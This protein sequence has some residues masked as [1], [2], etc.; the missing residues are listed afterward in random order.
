MVVPDST[1]IHLRTVINVARC[2]SIYDYTTAYWLTVTRCLTVF[3]QYGV[4]VPLTLDTLNIPVKLC[5]AGLLVGSWST[6]QDATLVYHH[7]PPVVIDTVL[8]G[9]S[10]ADSTVLLTHLPLTTNV[11]SPSPSTFGTDWRYDLLLPD[12]RPPTLVTSPVV[13]YLRRV[14]FAEFI[15]WQSYADA[16]SR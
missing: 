9:S 5:S 2:S 6:V 7:L 10:S 12:E 3:S 4:L 1:I 14:K 11:A 16:C 15:W 13:N 8:R